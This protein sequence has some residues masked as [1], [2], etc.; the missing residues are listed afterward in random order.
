V[1]KCGHED[2]QWL[3]AGCRDLSLVVGKQRLWLVLRNQPD[4]T[5]GRINSFPEHGASLKQLS[6]RDV[7]ELDIHMLIRRSLIS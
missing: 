3:L 5:L 7:V 6:G 2:W 1:A 4:A